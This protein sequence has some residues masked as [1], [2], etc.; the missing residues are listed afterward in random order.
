MEIKGK[1][2]AIDNL[3]MLKVICNNDRTALIEIVDSIDITIGDILS[4]DLMNYG[5]FVSIH[6]SENNQ[7]FQGLIQNLDIP[8]PH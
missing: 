1:V 3:G 5:E 2:F 7:T 6:S 8:K 4:G